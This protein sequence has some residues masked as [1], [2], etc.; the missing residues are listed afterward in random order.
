M[1]RALLTLLLLLLLNACGGLSGEPE[2]IA[3]APPQPTADPAIT[4]A[5]TWQPNIEKGAAIFA[6][7]CTECHGIGGDGRGDLILAGSIAQPLD[8]TDRVLVRAKSPLQWFE[9]ISKGKIENLMPPWENALRENER[10]DVTLYAYSLAYDE[11]QLKLGEQVWQQQCG[12][13]TLPTLIP[14]VYSDDDYGTQLNRELFASALTVEEQAAVVAYARMASLAYE[15]RAEQRETLGDIKGRVA[16][17]TVGGVVPAETVVQLQYGNADTGFSLAETPV[18]ESL[19]FMFEDLTLTNDLNYVLGVV[20]KGR[21][22]SRH[23]AAEEAS[24]LTITVYDVTEDPL[25]ISVGRIDLFVE[26]VKLAELGSGLYITQIIGFR[27]SSDRIYTSGRRFDDG[28]EAV[29]LVQFPQGAQALSNDAGGRYVFIENVGQLPNSVIDTLPVPPGNKH[30]VILEYFLPLAGSAK[31]E[32]DFNSVVDAE[33][34]V[35]LSA[36]LDVVG[37]S[38]SLEN[39]EQV[40]E[41]ARVYGG[42][43]TMESEARL[44][45]VIS[46]DP[47]AT[48]RGEMVVTQD[49]LAILILSA[50]VLGA[51]LFGGLGYRQ[52]RKGAPTSEIERLAQELARLDDAHD[53]GRLNHDLWHQKRRELK[54]RL[55]ELMGVAE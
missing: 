8:M 26:A 39:A 10:W 30:Q 25:V 21:L 13:C 9:I 54:A 22:F 16:H 27:N 18:D 36:G 42:W 24:D 37:D 4:L 52:W 15:D 31:F 48:S 19:G 50:G 6:E 2:I 55:A 33:V 3:T 1:L 29:L 43:L 20:Y 11:A 41:D 53:Q 28:R 17:G 40:T 46:G 51:A 32:Q 49:Q 45:F 5:A 44:S 7:H 35:M 34:R 23:L 47:D 14:P 38:L 12:D